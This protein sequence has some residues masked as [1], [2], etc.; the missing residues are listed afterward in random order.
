MRLIGGR[1][2]AVLTPAQDGA[3]AGAVLVGPADSISWVH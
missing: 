2:D 3:E 1:V